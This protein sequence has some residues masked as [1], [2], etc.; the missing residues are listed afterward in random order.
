MEL[1]GHQLLAGS[2]LTGYVN[3]GVTG[4]DPLNEAEQGL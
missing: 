1:T 2:G 3:R 4:G